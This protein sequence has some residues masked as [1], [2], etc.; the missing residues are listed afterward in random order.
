M[1]SDDNFKPSKQ[2]DSQFFTT[3]DSIGKIEAEI[4]VQ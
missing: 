2:N 1:T 3:H 4:S